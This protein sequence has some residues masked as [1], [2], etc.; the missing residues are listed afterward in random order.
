MPDIKTRDVVKGAIRTI[1]KS[2]TAAQ[3]MKDAYIRTKRKAENSV[4]SSDDSTSEYAA[5]CVSDGAETVLHEAGH[6]LHRQGKRRLA[7]P[8]RISPM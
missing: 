1:D 2:A 6:Q 4:Y 5:D 8:R 7:L 3:R